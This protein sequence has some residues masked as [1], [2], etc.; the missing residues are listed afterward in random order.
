MMRGKVYDPELKREIFACVYWDPL[1]RECL[2]YEDRPTV[3]RMY[4]CD[5]PE[6]AKVHQIWESMEKGKEDPLC[7][8]A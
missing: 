4:K 8:D 2:I 5:I 3:C 6:V 1:T 7:L